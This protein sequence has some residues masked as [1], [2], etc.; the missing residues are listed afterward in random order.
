MEFVVKE[1]LDRMLAQHRLRR[2][3]HE[4]AL[5]HYEFRFISR[6]GEIRDIYI[7]IDV[8]PGYHQ[9]RCIPSGHH[10]TKEG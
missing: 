4:S 3:D 2:V 8:I 1:D 5:A 6:L 7:T 10:R 9:E